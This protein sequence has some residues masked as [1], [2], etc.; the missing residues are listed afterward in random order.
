MPACVLRRYARALAHL[1]LEAWEELEE[2]GSDILMREALGLKTWLLMPKVEGANRTKQLRD[3]EMGNEVRKVLARMFCRIFDEVCQDQL[4]TAQQAFVRGREIVRNTV[5]MQTAM[6]EGME[7]AAAKPQLPPLLMLLLDCSKGYNN[8]DRGWVMRCLEA[9]RTPPRIKKMVGAM[10]MNISVLRLRG[11]EFG[12]MEFLAGLTQGCPLSCFLYVIAVDPLLAELERVWGVKDVSGFVDDWSIACKDFATLARVCLVVSEFE[13]ASGQRINRGKSAVVPART[14]T[15]EER[16]RCLE[17]WP[18]LKISYKERLLGVYIG[19]LATIED[20]YADPMAKFEKLMRIYTSERHAF[21]TSMRIMLVNIFLYTLFAYPNRHFYMPVGIKHA[22]EVAVLNF[23]TPVKW[24]KLG[25]FSHVRGMYGITVELCDLRLSNVASLLATYEKAEDL[26]DIATASLRRRGRVGPVR[27]R[28]LT[29]G[30]KVHP[31]ESWKSAFEFFNQTAQN[32]LGEVLVTARGI[33]G[34]STEAREP[35]Y[36]WLYAA[37]RK[38][39]SRFWNRYVVE[40]VGKDGWDGAGL[41]RRMHTIPRT[42]SQA[43]RWFLLK[44]HLKGPL[45]TG[46][47]AQA[48]VCEE[49]PCLLCAHGEDNTRHI[50][51]C[52]EVEKA[53]QAIWTKAQL[54]A[55]HGGLATLMLQTEVDGA[56]RAGCVAFWHAVWQVRRGRLRGN[57]FDGDREVATIV[58]NI[59]ES[60]WLAA[61]LQTNTRKERRAARVREPSP[62]GTRVAVYRSDG[63]SR[64]L[65]TGGKEAGFGA[66]Y[67]KAGARGRGPPAGTLREFVGNASNN[68]V[69]Y[70][71]VLKSM[72]RATRQSDRDVLFEVDSMLVAKQISGKWGCRST[73]LVQLYAECCMCGQMLDKRGVRWRIRHIYRE[74]NQAADTLANEAIDERASNGAWGDW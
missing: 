33:R 70:G 46:R 5:K 3:L 4:T 59:I 1:F 38:G 45:T 20:Q 40:R 27:G 57:E 55:D 72:R 25:L 47:L 21:S 65:Q 49:S 69:E 56:T 26:R 64:R 39:E 44:T 36:R 73:S 67:W 29:P 58:A 74:F 12:A 11:Q 13:R 32:S 7:D 62:V 48:R 71:G 68:I 61:S 60:P 14:L 10:M 30:A 9:A 51:K 18:D 6:R 54:P 19:P 15:K 17:E 16:E 43:H 28:D 31:A 24:A 66:G 53:Y 8:M 22:V 37:L 50:V 35:V 42:M 2:D 23:V 41:L 34:P 52:P 63:A